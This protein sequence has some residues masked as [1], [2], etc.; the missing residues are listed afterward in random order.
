MYAIIRTSFFVRALVALAGTALFLIGALP[1][2]SG[3]MTE[4][5]T[6]EKIEDINSKTNADTAELATMGLSSKIPIAS[7]FAPGGPTDFEMTGLGFSEVANIVGPFLATPPAD[8]DEAARA[9]A[10]AS[11]KADLERQL[12]ELLETTLEETWPQLTFTN[13]PCEE[14]LDEDPTACDDQEGEEDAEAQEQNEDEAEPDF[15][16]DLAFDR[17]DLLSFRLDQ[18]DAEFDYTTSQVTVEV[19]TTTLSIEAH[20]EGEVTAGLSWPASSFVA[21]IDDDVEFSA[22]KMDLTFVID[23]GFANGGHHDGCYEQVVDY[24]VTLSWIELQGV[25]T[26]LPKVS[27]FIMTVDLDDVVSE[28][29]VRDRVHGLI[30]GSAPVL[31]QVPIEVGMARAHDAWFDGPSADGQEPTSIVLEWAYDLDL[32]GIFECDRCPNDARNDEDGDGI[33]YSEDNCPTIGNPN[34]DDPDGDGLGN[35]CDNDDDGDGLLDESDNCSQN[36]NASQDDQDGD[37]VGDMCDNCLTLYNPLQSDYDGDHF[38]NECDPDMDGDGVANEKD[39]CPI[40]A[41]VDQD[42]DDK[43]GMGNV[44][45]DENLADEEELMMLVDVRFQ[46]IAYVFQDYGV[47][48]GPW[49]SWEKISALFD[50][51]DFEIEITNPLVEIGNFEDEWTLGYIDAEDFLWENGVPK[52]IMCDHVSSM[53]TMDPRV[54]TALATQFLE[55]NLGM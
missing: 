9:E 29:F 16:Y 48:E 5:E 24:I 50:T 32:D 42:D 51:E 33:C 23:F 18:V 19:A 47:A 37:G 39:N 1:G 11:A 46:A 43:D 54:S 7:T 3:E 21:H 22:D 36:H 27:T 6:R 8:A 41:N 40:H 4:E 53:L 31:A 49:G 13:I 2:C 14:M 26:D 30:R 44:C 45:D 12:T 17:L 15:Y 25:E 10:E 55:D 34:Q 35:A 20:V 28:D 52:T 38:G